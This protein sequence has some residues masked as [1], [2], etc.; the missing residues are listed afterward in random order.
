MLVNFDHI[1]YVAASI[2]FAFS[3]V[4]FPS[5]L[6]SNSAAPTHAVVDKVF[7]V[8]S[9]GTPISFSDM[10]FPSFFISELST[11]YNSRIFSSGS[12]SHF[13]FMLPSVGNCSELECFVI[14][15]SVLG[16]S[17]WWSAC[18]LSAVFLPVNW[19]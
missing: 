11:E 5:S 10:T 18:S 1:L 13:D 15:F 16:S 17:N 14:T 9:T 19:V 8:P 12:S 6:F 7:M 4:K 2:S 3:N